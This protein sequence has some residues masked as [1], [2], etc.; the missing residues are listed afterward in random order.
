MPE[1]ELNETDPNF[2]RRSTDVFACLEGVATDHEAFLRRSVAE[3][4]DVKK[5]WREAAPAEE[6]LEKAGGSAAK[7]QVIDS[8][9]LFQ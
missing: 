5:T 9:P 3:R 2:R 4:E 7:Q 8:S 1:F 6:F